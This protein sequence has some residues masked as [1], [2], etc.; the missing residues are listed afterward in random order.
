VAGVAQAEA[1]IIAVKSPRILP[2]GGDYIGTIRHELIHVLLARNVDP[3]NLPRWLNEGVTMTLSREYRWESR[4]QI[5]EMYLRGQII[6]YPDLDYA[7]AAPGSEMQFGEAYAQS[8]SM[9]RFLME[10]LGD[11]GFWSLLLSLRDQDFSHALKQYAGW[12]PRDFYFSWKKSLWKLALVSTVVS[13]LSL[14]QIMAVL[15]VVA[16]WRKRRHGQR[17]MKRWEQE[18]APDDAEA[19]DDSEFEPWN[20]EEDDEDDVRRW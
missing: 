7:L 3:D 15:V 1:G 14:F 9:T 17:I 11:D 13:G 20:D 10:Q 2:E 18:E 5:A 19:L 12:S 6:N 16:Y 4:I 8:L